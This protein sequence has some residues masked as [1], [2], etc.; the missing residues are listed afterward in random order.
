MAPDLNKDGKAA[1]GWK[2]LIL[3]DVEYAGV[4]AI[5]PRWEPDLLNC[6]VSVYGQND[7]EHPTCPTGSLIPT[8]SSMAIC[9]PRGLLA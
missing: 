8:R 1:G 2:E 4:S 6:D 9:R 3:Q 5:Q 7:L